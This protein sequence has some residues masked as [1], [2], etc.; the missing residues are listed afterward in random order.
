[1]GPAGPHPIP[2][3]QTWVPIEH[4]APLYEWFIQKHLPLNVLIHPLTIHPKLDHTVR[5][6]FMGKAFELKVNGLHD[7]PTL[8]SQYPH[9]KLGYAKSKN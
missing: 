1:M 4:F 2:Q 8:T 3:F 7:W 6:V 5:A 9:I